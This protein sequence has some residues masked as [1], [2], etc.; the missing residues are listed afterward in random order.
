MDN[1]ITKMYEA[2]NVYGINSKEALD[3]S[4]ELDVV[5]A[6]EQLAMYS[7]YKETIRQ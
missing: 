6:K 4:Q 2:I 5:I 1:L 7:S 3:I